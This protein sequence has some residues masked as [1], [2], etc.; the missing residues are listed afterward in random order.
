MVLRRGLH[1]GQESPRRNTGAGGAA[2]DN[3]ATGAPTNSRSRLNRL[4]VAIAVVPMAMLGPPNSANE[5]NTSDAV[6]PREDVGR[7]RGAVGEPADAIR[8]GP[9]E[10]VIAPPPEVFD[11]PAAPSPPPP[12][13]LERGGLE[14]VVPQAGVWA[15]VIG[16]NDYPGTRSD[17]QSAVNDANDV[18]EALIGYGVPAER[19][20]SVL[21]R[22]AS[23]DAIASAADWL[24]AHSAPEATAVFFYA[25]HVR[26]VSGQE[27]IVGADGA[28]VSDAALAERLRPLPARNAWIAIAAC[29]GG[30]FTELLAPGRILTAAAGANDLAYE[31]LSFRRS[32]LVQYL[33]RQAMIERRAPASVQTAFRYAVDALRRDYP[34]RVPE[35]IDNARRPVNFGAP[36]SRPQEPAQGTPPPREGGR[37]SQATPSESPPPPKSNDGEACVLTIGRTITCE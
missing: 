35:Q 34:N 13:A 4:L 26:K 33:V 16:I 28:L 32:Y 12:A 5:T 25:G 1:R 37:D 9:Y 7:I 20:L 30:G 3:D 8:D 15:V 22:T 29:F 23:G 10:A 19:V 18:R 6:S 31:N 11:A 14:G 17:L 21:D 2:P 27:A 36:S 24:V